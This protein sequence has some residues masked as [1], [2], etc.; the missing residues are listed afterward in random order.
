[1]RPPGDAKM[2]HGLRQ[3]GI[4][5]RGDLISAETIDWRG[6]TA[7]DQGHRVELGKRFTFTMLVIFLAGSSPGETVFRMAGISTE[8]RKTFIGRADG[9][10]RGGSESGAH[11]RR[12][13]LR[14]K[15][16]EENFSL[17]KH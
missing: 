1:M 7:T 4:R 14:T 16:V 13:G 5:L 15:K 12:D 17:P 6:L 8:E 10:R 11:L 9:S 2:K 3:D